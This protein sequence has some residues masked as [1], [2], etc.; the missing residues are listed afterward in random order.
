MLNSTLDLK[1]IFMAHIS[2]ITVCT[3][4]IVLTVG[5]ISRPFSENVT[6]PQTQK[7]T[8]MSQCQHTSDELKMNFPQNESHPFKDDDITE[9]DPVNSKKARQSR[10]QTRVGDIPRKF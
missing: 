4:R 6:R 10:V 3:D 9:S 7:V 2:S 8:T 5:T 1:L